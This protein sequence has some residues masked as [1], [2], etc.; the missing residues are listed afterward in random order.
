M[1][2]DIGG[3]TVR[4]VESRRRDRGRFSSV[5]PYKS[6]KSASS[7]RRGEEVSRSWYW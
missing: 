3:G 2:L 7:S 5:F 6:S 4:V 1:E